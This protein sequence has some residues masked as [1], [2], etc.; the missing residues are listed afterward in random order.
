MLVK[1]ELPTF[2]LS[3]V[4]PMLPSP[5][6]SLSSPLGRSDAYWRVARN[7]FIWLGTY[8]M[9]LVRAGRYGMTSSVVPD[10]KH[11]FVFSGRRK[12][13]DASS[14]SDTGFFSEH[15]TWACLGPCKEAIVCGN[16][17]LSVVV[18]V[19]EFEIRE[20]KSASSPNDYDSS[21]C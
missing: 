6:F 20:L 7:L 1:L 5:P 21:E 17:C 2:S 9:L 11:L 3:S 10:P 8:A 4:D 19:D 16:T 18:L 15:D 13:T 14:D 12:V